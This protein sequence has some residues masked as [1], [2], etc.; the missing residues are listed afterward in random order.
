MVSKG[1]NEKLTNEPT[2][3]AENSRLKEKCRKLK[4]SL[5]KYSEWQ[6]DQSNK[7]K[8]LQQ[9]NS[10]LKEQLEKSEMKYENLVN[11]FNC[12]STIGQWII[13][14]EK[15]ESKLDKTNNAIE[16]IKKFVDGKVEYHQSIRSMD[17]SLY[18]ELQKI[19]DD[20]Q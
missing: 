9:E 3:T 19:L 1:E 18:V 2:I 16:K 10:Q 12:Q 6:F 15:L 14:N 11:K 7:I 13:Q 5:D 17:T 8:I 4:L 20:V